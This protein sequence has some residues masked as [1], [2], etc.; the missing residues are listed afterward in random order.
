M[1]HSPC[2]RVSAGAE[3]SAKS[4]G[5]YSTTSISLMRSGLA[6]RG[7]CRSPRS[8]SQISIGWREPRLAKQSNSGTPEMLNVR[9]TTWEKCRTR[10]SDW[11]QPMKPYKRGLVVPQLLDLLH[12]TW[13]NT[14]HAKGNTR[15][16]VLS[17]FTR[18]GA[19]SCRLRGTHRQMNRSAAREQQSTTVVYPRY[20]PN[21]AS[22]GWSHGEATFASHTTQAHAYTRTTMGG[23]AMHVA[24][25][26]RRAKQLATAKPKAAKRLMEKS[27]V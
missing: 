17:K 20:A 24:T 18:K 1:Q 21:H 27:W 23:P 26:Q 15:P 3:G 13:P 7:V 12:K 4:S 16:N 22:K 19:W 8:A 6:A 9:K 14:I 2:G 11:N 5:V 25:R 10:K